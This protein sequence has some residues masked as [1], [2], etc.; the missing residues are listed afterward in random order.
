MGK[1]EFIGVV[2]RVAWG[3][4]DTSIDEDLI[5]IVYIHRN[6]LSRLLD[7]QDVLLK[8]G[9]GN[10]PQ[11]VALVEGVGLG[12]A[13]GEVEG[14]LHGNSLTPLLHYYAPHRQNLPSV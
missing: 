3:G 6:D 2:V 13:V 9:N 12:E 1:D 8:Q 10:F 5:K 14:N 11:P 7:E 4:E